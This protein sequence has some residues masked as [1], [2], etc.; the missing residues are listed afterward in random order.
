MV[1]KRKG[2][3]PGVVP[4]RRLAVKK[5]GP[6]EDGGAANGERHSV[7]RVIEFPKPPADDGN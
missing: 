2:K 1:R 4:V 6:T 3:N 7:K 5:R